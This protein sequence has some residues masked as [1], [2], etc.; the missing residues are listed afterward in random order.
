VKVNAEFLPRHREQRVQHL[1]KLLG[2]FKGVEWKNH[3]RAQDHI[4][5]IIRILEEVVTL[6]KQMITLKRKDTRIEEEIARAFEV[7]ISE[8]MVKLPE[9]DD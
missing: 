2:K 9:P 5:E 8:H 7:L 4:Q 6:E 1:K 3:G